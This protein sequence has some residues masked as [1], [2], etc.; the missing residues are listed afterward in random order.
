MPDFELEK[1]AGGIVAGV[2]EAGRGPWAGPVVAAAAVLDPKT[3]P[4]ILE[5]RLDDSKK[6][7]AKIRADL[8]HALGSCAQIGIG[9][10]SVVEIDT[11]NI[12]AATMLAM[13]RAVLNL[14]VSPGHALVDGNQPPELPCYVQTIVG[15]DALSL[16][17]AAASIV[18]KVTRD[19]IMTKLA[20]KHPGYGWERNAGYG[21]KAHREGL[22]RLGVNKHHRRSFKPIAAFLK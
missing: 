20:L 9:T 13:R 10:A 2:D 15:G 4:Q 17:I 6:L 12:L 1:K 3:L 16:S 18:A 14:P 5:S 21:T 8:F 11:H 19:Q 22:E 7:S